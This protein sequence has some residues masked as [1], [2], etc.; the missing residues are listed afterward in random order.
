MLKLK[1]NTPAVEEVEELLAA[2]LL[3]GSLEGDLETYGNAED[4]TW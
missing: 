3:D 2:D 4:F 1:Y